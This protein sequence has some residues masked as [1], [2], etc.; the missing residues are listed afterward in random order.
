MARPTLDDV[1]GAVEH[2]ILGRPLQA[3]E[4]EPAVLEAL[5]DA[6]LASGDWRYAGEPIDDAAVPDRYV[7]ELELLYRA[8]RDRLNG[9]DES[10]VPVVLGYDHDAITDIRGST[11]L[12]RNEVG[13]EYMAEVQSGAV[14]IDEDTRFFGPSAQH[15]AIEAMVPDP[16]QVA[17]LDALKAMH[18][19][20][21]AETYREQMLQVEPVWAGPVRQ[22]RYE[23]VEPYADKYDLTIVGE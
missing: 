20:R 17:S 6:T 10:P 12:Y 18:W 14:A 23:T 19:A 2:D 7:E 16:D 11:T 22:T 13:K 1:Y 15:D 8:T 3:D 9:L 5:I 4:R 21:N